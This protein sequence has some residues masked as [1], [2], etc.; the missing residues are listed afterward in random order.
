MSIGKIKKF[1]VANGYKNEIVAN[2]YK[3]DYSAPN[4]NPRN[5]ITIMDNSLRIE[6]GDDPAFPSYIIYSPKFDML[7]NKDH[8]CLYWLIG[9]LIVN[10]LISRNFKL[11]EY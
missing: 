9:C 4:K 6:F 3:Y 1:L 7:N 10:K 8:T 11:Y 5:R 2:Q